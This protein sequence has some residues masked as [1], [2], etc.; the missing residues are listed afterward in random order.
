MK[1]NI[2]SFTTRP[3]W[4][5]RGRLWRSMA[6]LLLILLLAAGCKK[7]NEFRNAKPTSEVSV[8]TYDFLKSQQGLYDTLLHLI[9]IAGLADTLKTENITFFAPQDYSIRTGLYNLNYTRG[10]YGF[11]GNWTLDS[12]PPAVWDTLLRRYMMPGKVT[13]DSLDY[14]D[15]VN[16]NTLSYGYPMNG[17]T[18]PTNASGIIAGGPTIIQLS[19]MNR[20]RF[21]R[22]WSTSITQS[23]D[24]KTANGWL[25]VLESKHVFGFISLVPI[26]FPYSLN[27]IQAPYLGLPSPIP[28]TIEVE[29]FDDGGEGLAYHDADANNNGGQ[30]RTERVDIEN[31]GEGGFNIGWTSGSEWLEYTVEVSVSGDYDL[32]VRAAANDEPG[33]D[34]HVEFDGVDITGIMHCPRTGGWQS[35]ITLSKTVTLTAGKHVMRFVLNTGGYNINKFIFTKL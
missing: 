20:S 25:H 32:G 13:A 11:P 2:P 1:P 8:N 19:D 27:P 31:C 35:Y 17:K 34:F 21:V 23:I 10:K 3:A 28:G 9:D 12:I 26:A 7:Y 15:G 24:L 16:L 22:D 14:A 33:G 30:Y 18:A 4:Q 29:D 5:R 6:G